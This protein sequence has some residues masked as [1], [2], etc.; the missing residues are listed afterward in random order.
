M[1]VAIADLQ[2]SHPAFIRSKLNGETVARY[3]EII[4]SM[5]PIDVMRVNGTLVPAD[6]NHR[7]AG[8]ELAGRKEIE[9]LGRGRGW[10]R[11]PDPTKTVRQGRV[12]TCPRC[13]GFVNQRYDND[14]YCMPCGWTDPGKPDLTAGN[15]PANVVPSR[16]LGRHVS[17]LQEDEVPLTLWRAPAKNGKRGRRTR[18]HEWY[19]KRPHGGTNLTQFRFRVLGQPSTPNAKLK[20]FRIHRVVVN[21]VLPLNMMEKEWSNLKTV[22][23]DA[24][25]AVVEQEP[26]T[27]NG[28]FMTV[29][30]EPIEAAPPPRHRSY[31]GHQTPRGQ[32]G[33]Q[34]H[35]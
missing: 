27:P 16:P 5:P 21:Q 6:G 23:F 3:A 13:G 35:A 9:A 24:V 14:P 4:D 11:N 30:D 2:R 15:E 26:Q 8:A 29:F 12:M 32:W 10:I 25:R 1:K 20:K 19:A 34:I 28:P 7:V 33:A 18:R 22:L 17:R 31:T